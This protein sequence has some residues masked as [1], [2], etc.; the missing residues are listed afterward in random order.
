M[1]MRAF[2]GVV[3]AQLAFTAAAWA[4]DVRITPDLSEISVNSAGQ[5]VTIRRIQDT[6]N[7]LTGE[8]AR[9]SRPCPD[10][11]LQPISASDGVA[12]AGELEVLSFLQNE[13]STG[14]GLLIDTRLPDAF[15]DGTIPGAVNVPHATLDAQNPFRTEILRALGATQTGSGGQWEFS[16]AFSLMLFCDGPWCSSAQDAVR[17]LVSSG[18]PPAKLGYYRGGM[19]VWQLMGLTVS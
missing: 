10:Q 12:T 14:R 9:T 18:Y 4:Q 7:T 2:A 11:C 6:E 15:A 13:A 5:S 1:K 19:Q 17:S 16:G 3:L 8:W